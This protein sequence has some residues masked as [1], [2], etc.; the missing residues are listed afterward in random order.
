VLLRI[1]M[2]DAI[3]CYGQFFT[4]GMNDTYT[5]SIQLNLVMSVERTQCH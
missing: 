5:I 4:V 3:H 1:E 2:S